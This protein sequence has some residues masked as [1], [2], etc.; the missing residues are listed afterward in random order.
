[1]CTF[2]FNSRLQIQKRDESNWYIRHRR[3]LSNQYLVPLSALFS[4]VCG[5]FYSGIF[6][7][8]YPHALSPS[9][10]IFS[11]ECPETANP[12]AIA[13]CVPAAVVVSVLAYLVRDLQEAL[14]IKAELGV[15]ALFCL[16]FLLGWP[17]V[18]G[19]SVFIYS[20][21]W[22][23]FYFV[24]SLVTNTLPVL[25]TFRAQ[26][27]VQTSTVSRHN[28][29]DDH[30]YLLQ[31]SKVG[32]TTGKV[33]PISGDSLHIATDSVNTDKKLTDLNSVTAL[34][35]SNR[36]AK[37]EKLQSYIRECLAN[38]TRIRCKRVMRS[39]AGF[40]ALERFLVTELSS[41]NLHFWR[42]VHD[43]ERHVKQMRGQTSADVAE[44]NTAA[45][46]LYQKLIV[47]W[48]PL[49]VNIAGRTRKAIE[50]KLQMLDSLASSS[51]VSPTSAATIDSQA[52]N[53]STVATGHSKSSQ[54]A[55]SFKTSHFAS[56]LA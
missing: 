49:E 28:S 43:Y 42:S 36:Q 54:P 1:M 22:A 12:V 35:A 17:F 38:N 32:S 16:A 55:G 26:R 27:A 4:I 15:L 9:V 41:E 53:E 44:L 25:L 31:P 46:A 14:W 37:D 52:A 3:Y 51:P 50:E 5:G 56:V 30:S 2:A 7:A 34:P 6:C 13:Y 18:V 39:P 21:Y 33:L 29:T 19:R 20:V 47:R 8:V 24:G 10:D 48:A 11:D 40:L 23:A 45:H